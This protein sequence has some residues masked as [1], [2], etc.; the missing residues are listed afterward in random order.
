MKL[1]VVSATEAEIA[2]F[3]SAKEGEGHADILVTGPG[4]PATIYQLTKALLKNSYDLVIN[5][6]IAG[7]FDRNLPTGTVVQVV[8]DGFADLGAEDGDAFLDIFRLGLIDPDALPFEKGKL[9]NDFRIPELR[10]ADGLTVNTA[11]GNEARIEAIRARFPAHTES[12]EG[13]GFFYV[14][15]NEGVNCLQLRA[16]SNY[17][18]KRNRENWNIPLAVKQLNAALA[19]IVRKYSGAW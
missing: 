18:E 7:S 17:V 9:R 8:S 10:E 12:M 13:A 5:A 16:V 14:C 4:V 11:H 19:G 6:G 3:S 1:L 15:M 2:P